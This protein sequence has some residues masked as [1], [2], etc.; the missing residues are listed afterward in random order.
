MKSSLTSNMDEQQAKEIV[1]EFNGSY[2]LRQRVVELLRKDID[3]WYN[4]MRSDEFLFSPNFS[5]LQAERLG[6]INSHYKLISL[7]EK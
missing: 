5:L 3:G 4:E 1:G 2:H 7:L 6:R